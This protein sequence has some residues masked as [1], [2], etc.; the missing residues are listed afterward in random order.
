M[1]NDVIKIDVQ[2]ELL[3]ANGR[4]N[5]HIKATLKKGELTVLFGDSGAGKTTLL[6][7]IAGLTTPDKGY[8]KTGNLVW[9]DAET[10]INLPPQ[11]RNIGYVFQ[12]YTLFPNMTVFENITFG[13]KEKNFNY[14]SEL[15][16]RFGISEF[17]NRKPVNLSGGQKQRVALAR[18][19]A[20]KPEFLLLDEP[21]SALD[22]NIRISSQD[23]ILK[24]HQF[25]N[26]T[27]LLVSHDLTEVFRLAQNVMK[28]ENGKITRCGKPDK[29]FINNQIS[30]KVQ[31]TGSVIRIEK[32]DTFYLLTVVTGMNQIIKVTAFPNDIKDL[33][34]GAQVIVF[35]K[36]LN[37]II[38]KL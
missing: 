17:T 12:D 29:L 23:E 7:M 21:L 16:E 3:S 10:K 15:I 25:G 34:E 9:F 8:I 4:L 6:R 20:R 1:E 2:K 11:K 35:S 32:Q 38:M 27:T 36:A 18:T 19:L 26:L 37:P 28:I 22:S 33:Y 5:L 24:A 31:L 30:G 13:Q 14:V